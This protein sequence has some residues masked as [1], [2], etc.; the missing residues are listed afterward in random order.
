MADVAEAQAPSQPAEPELPPKMAS[1]D[2]S[3]SSNSIVENDSIISNRKTAFAH[4][5]KSTTI[6]TAPELTTEQETKYNSLHNTV[7][8]WTSLPNT[9]ATNASSSPLTE[10]EQMWLSRECI[11]RYLRATTWNVAQS[12]Q[13]LRAT[14]IW[15][16]EYGLYTKLTAEY[17][18][19]E[20]E[21]GKQ[22][23]LGYDNAGRPCHYLNPSRQNTEKSDRQIEHLVFMMERAIDL[24][25]PGQETLALLMNFAETSRGQGATLQQGRQTMYVLQHHYPERLG[26]ALLMNLPWHISAFMKL[27]FPF[28][29]PRTKEK[30]VFNEDMRKYVPPEQL[31]RSHGGDVEFEYEHGVY[32]LSLIKLAEERRRL[33]HERWVNGGKMIGEYELYM[34]GGQDESLCSTMNVANEELAEKTA[35]ISLDGKQAE[36]AMTANGE[37]K[38]A[39][40][41]ASRVDA[42]VSE[43]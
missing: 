39:N 31:R 40:E 41:N 1:T 12:A 26:K 33:Q 38:K 27:V 23:I 15:R 5:S 21:T 13:R 37:G 20:N 22:W 17:V 7:S 10:A 19:V 28:I 14:L 34:K 16:R 29:D 9:S 8:S 30:I 24:M 43:I 3:T 18:Q 36:T 6:P 4:P 2:F 25:P 42:A 11:L 35:G 32:W